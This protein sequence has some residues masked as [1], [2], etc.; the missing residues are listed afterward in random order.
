MKMLHQA[1]SA[2][3][4]VTVIGSA[5]CGGEITFGAKAGFA[6]SNITETP[7]EWEDNTSFKAGFSG[8]AFLNYSMTGSFSLQPELL[9]VSRGVTSN[10]YDG[11]ILVDV[12]ATF[13]YFELPVLAKYSFLEGKAFR[14]CVYAGP[15]FAYA[16]ASDLEISASILS[17][18]VDFSS[19]THTTDF[20]M[21]AGAGF[22]YAVGG[23]TLTFDARFHRGFTNV[24]I[25]G[26]FEINGST[27]TISGDDF[28]NYGFAFMV[29][30]L[31]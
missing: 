17:A 1:V 15:S 20:A 10:L 2:F 3:V 18:S 13:D 25:S 23:G 16:L 5:A 29:G 21:V 19:L 28:K 24:L 22:D 4:L 7:E 27:Q 12:T 9:Y 8:G 31:F 26:D 6:V 30:Y 14:P 11:I